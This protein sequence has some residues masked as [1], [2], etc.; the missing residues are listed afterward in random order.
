M[1]TIT[2]PQAQKT[3]LLSNETI[4][5]ELESWL[6]KFNGDP[7]LN[8]LLF[9]NGLCQ[10]IAKDQEIAFHQAMSKFD[11]IVMAYITEKDVG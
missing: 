10:Q 9:R 2:T 1:T 6:V 7:S 3:S 11:A 4:L 8:W 5:G